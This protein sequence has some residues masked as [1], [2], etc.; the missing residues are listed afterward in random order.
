MYSNRIQ[1]YESSYSE[2]NFWMKL[3]RFAL[4]AG[5]EVIEKALI[6]FFTM[7]EPQVPVWAKTVVISALGYFICP[8]DAIPDY[9]PVI[10]YSDDLVVLGAALATISQYVT[11]EIKEQSKKVVS[12]WFGEC[13]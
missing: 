7:Q 8:F 6:L 2:S 9:I 3:K 4:K 12:K 11:P 13:Y 10:G 5:R 1:K